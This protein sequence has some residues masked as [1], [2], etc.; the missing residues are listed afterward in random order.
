[1]TEKAANCIV[2]LAAATTTALRTASSGKLEKLTVS[3]DFAVSLTD[4][5]YIVTIKSANGTASTSVK[6]SDFKW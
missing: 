2:E 1:M 5:K 4:T 6:Y 3:F